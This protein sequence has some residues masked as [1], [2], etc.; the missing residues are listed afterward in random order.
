MTTNERKNEF[1]TFLTPALVSFGAAVFLG[2]VQILV[3]IPLL[4]LFMRLNEFSNPLYGPIWN[5]IILFLSQILGTV[6][7]LRWGIPWLKVENV[8]QFPV[9]WYT[10]ISNLFLIS[11]TW[12]L[13]IVKT[14]IMAILIDFFQ[15]ETPRT[16]LE[17]FLIQEE[18]ISPITIIIF[19]APLVIGA[20][21][22]EELVY[23]RLLIPLLE[24]RGM[25]TG[26]AVLASSIFFTLLHLPSDL[27]Y[28][29]TTGM[30][31]HISSVVIIA[32][33]LGISYVKTRN[34]VYPIL[35]HGVVNGISAVPTILIEGSD[36]AVLYK[37]FSFILIVM[38]GILYL[39]YLLWRNFKDSQTIN[40]ESIRSKIS[41]NNE[42]FYGYLI[43]SLGL[44]L[45][46][47]IS[48][49]FLQVISALFISPIVLIILLVI[50]RNT[51]YQKEKLSEYHMTQ[52]AFLTVESSDEVEH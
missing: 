40:I 9:N 37:I 25:N 29:N 16:G 49:I 18:I 13:I 43:I 22:F 52:E 3:A 19:F 5:L 23:R 50:I 15:L 47:T 24:E 7:I 28:G 30:I 51:E 8:R 12:A 11:L 33:V 6:I 14:I 27:L 32:F 42:G 31:L 45:L 20:P 2:V 41:I 4:G 46:H 21:L 34:I 10:F 17:A 44:L 36:L 1:L 39:L 26:G 38:I 48:S 35:I